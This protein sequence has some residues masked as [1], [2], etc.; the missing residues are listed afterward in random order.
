MANW[1]D[2]VNN[3]LTLGRSRWLCYGINKERRRQENEGRPGVRPV[4]DG[5]GYS[6]CQ[7]AVRYKR[8]PMENFSRHWVRGRARPI[9]T[10]RPFLQVHHWMV[11]PSPPWG[12]AVGFG[13]VSHGLG[14]NLFRP[15]L[16]GPQLYQP[17]PPAPNQEEDAADAPSE[18][19]DVGEGSS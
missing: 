2:I 14:L 15:C 10:P 6:E 7:E 9:L 12:A 18:P 1:E 3:C 4:V 19:S 17:P 5:R 8:L 11:P 13:P 16:A